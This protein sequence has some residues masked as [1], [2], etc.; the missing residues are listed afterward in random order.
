[1]SLMSCCTYWCYYSLTGLLRS[2]FGAS[3]LRC[4]NDEV[5]ELPRGV[6]CLGKMLLKSAV[7]EGKNT[8]GA[9]CILLSAPDV[10]APGLHPW[11]ALKATRYISSNSLSFSRSS[12]S[13]TWSFVLIIRFSP[14]R[15]LIWTLVWARCSLCG[16]S[17]KGTNSCSRFLLVVN[18]FE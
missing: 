18:A 4:L 15:L 6:L 1:M 8:C 7:Y 5:R 10:A 17:L 14:I 16:V 13:S 12:F 9:S 11:L 2:L 3:M